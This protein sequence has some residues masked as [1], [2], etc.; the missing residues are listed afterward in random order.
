MTAS[1]RLTGDDRRLNG[2]LVGM[3][4]SYRGRIRAVADALKIHR[5]KPLPAL[6]VANAMVWFGISTIGA[7]GRAARGHDRE[8]GRA[9]ACLL[10]S[11]S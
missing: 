5:V 9:L 1:S 11:T 3:A 2:Y 4:P 10:V 7:S 6:L 8:Q